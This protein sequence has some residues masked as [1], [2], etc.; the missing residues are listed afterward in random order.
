MLGLGVQRQITH[1][2]GPRE[3]MSHQESCRATPT[4]GTIR[5]PLLPKQS[6]RWEHRVVILVSLPQFP[7]LYIGDSAICLSFLICEL[8]TMSSHWQ[9]CC[10]D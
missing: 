9:G 3:L 10:E 2:T 7:H 1:V 5:I 6:P 4:N 8:G